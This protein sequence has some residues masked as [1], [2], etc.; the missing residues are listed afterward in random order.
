MGAVSD[1]EQGQAGLRPPRLTA[2]LRLDRLSGLY[3]L[4]TLIVAF[5]LA[6]PNSFP[7]TLTLKTTL[8][9]YSVTGI[10]AL[11]ALV[12]FAAGLIDLSFAGVAGLGMVAATW[13]SL[14]TGLPGGV[15]A[16]AVV[17]GGAGCGAFSGWFVT[18]LKVNSL[19]V[20]LGVATVALGLSELISSG[21]TLTGHWSS[22]VEGL[23]QNYVWLFP[24]PALYLLVLA[25]VLY[26]VIEHT[27]PGRRILATG[28]NPE[29]ARLVGLRV[30]RVQGFSLITSGAVAGFAGMLLAVQIGVATT[31]TGPGYLLPAV[32]A[33]FLG[34]TQIRN[35]VNVWGTVLAVFLIGTG[36]KG[37]ELLGA[38]PWVNDFFNGTVLLLA[39]GL[40][41]HSQRQRTR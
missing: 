21:N 6:A 11:G 41:A 8:A 20:T 7:T 31:A 23:A 39:V 37:L 34:E 36:I 32:A 33:L 14:H 29:A 26:Y 5:S 24:L 12:P 16:V 1:I 38:A 18:R 40:A 13:L 25:L 30:G 17:I 15:I 22:G 19:V 9:D 3:V 35:R 10:L 28:S 4:V 27:A 2:R